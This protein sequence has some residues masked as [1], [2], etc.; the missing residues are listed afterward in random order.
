MRTL[1]LQV[2]LGGPALAGLLWL[3]LSPVRGRWIRRAVAGVVAG[4]AN[5]AAWAVFWLAFQGEAPAWRSFEPT[6]LGSTVAAAAGVATLLAAL[7]A[8]ELGRGGTAVAGAALGASMSAVVA[9]SYATSVAV[10]VLVLPLPTIAAIVASAAERE[11]IGRPGL[12]GLAAADVVGAIGFAL[13]QARTDATALLPSEGGAALLLLAAG[14][15]KAGALPGIATW[16]LSAHEGPGGLVSVALRGQGVALAVLGGLVLGRGEPTVTVAAAAAAL[17]VLAGATAVASSTEAAWFAGVAGTAAAVPFFALG[18]GG[19]VGVRAFLLLFPAFL[20]AVGAL[21]L[22]AR[23]SWPDRRRDRAWSRPLQ[24]ASAGVAAASLL[25]LPLGAGFPGTWLALSLAGARGEA[26]PWWLLALGGAA[27]GLGLAA[28][29]S[30]PLI[31]AVRPGPWLAAVGAVVAVAL[32]YMG[33]QPVRLGVGWWLRVEAELGTPVLLPAAGLPHLPPVGGRDLVA[34]G[35]AAVLVVALVVLLARGMAE[36]PPPRSRPRGAVGASRSTTSSGR[37]SAAAARVE[38][39]A[40]R[41]GVDLGLALVFEA[42]ALVLAALV[43]WTAA[44][45]GFL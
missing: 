31:R 45:A 41:R 30:V 15:A 35:G 3:V 26:S 33:A 17:I 28:M 9:T 34:V 25:G 18:L 23:P 14:A 1:L 24:V 11:P 27:L 16:R 20:L 38:A 39:E 8:D 44:R 43:V 19:A 29:A 40:R 2:A 42:G 5:A 10:Q 37:F 4:G 7:R 13:A 6:L 21:T 36:R 22:L 12:I 32:L